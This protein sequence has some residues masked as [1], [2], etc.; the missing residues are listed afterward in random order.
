VSAEH[1]W[2]NIPVTLIVRGWGAF[3]LSAMF[4]LIKQ[5]EEFFR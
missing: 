2:R 4:K 1:S 3:S 5:L